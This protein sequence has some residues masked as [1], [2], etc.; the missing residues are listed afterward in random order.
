MT[1]LRV[2]MSLPAVLLCAASAG[3][4]AAD[5]RRAARAVEPASVQSTPVQVAVV[6]NVDFAAQQDLL[7]WSSIADSTNPVD[8]RA[9]LQV[10]PYGRFTALAAARLQALATPS[11]AEIEAGWN[12]VMRRIINE[13]QP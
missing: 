6:P 10:F 12:D 5:E 1:T 7:F 2:W 8:F 4:Q 3:A 11:A 9:Y 13:G